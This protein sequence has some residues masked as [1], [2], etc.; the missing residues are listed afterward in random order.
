VPKEDI[1]RSGQRREQEPGLPKIIQ[2]WNSYVYGLVQRSTEEFGVR[3]DEIEDAV[4]T[5]THHPPTTHPSSG[6][7][8]V[9]GT[10]RV[11]PW[12][13]NSSP[14]GGREVARGPYNLE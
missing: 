5:V 4:Q 9:T 6:H 2:K 8:E 7:C 12:Q 11:E 14:I 3:V 1:D 10:N 13:R